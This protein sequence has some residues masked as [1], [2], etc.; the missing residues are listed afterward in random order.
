MASKVE[1]DVI[2]AT[3]F[4]QKL[5][6]IKTLFVPLDIRIF[7][8]KSISNEN[9]A[10]KLSKNGVFWYF[11]HILHLFLGFLLLTFSMYLFAALLSTLN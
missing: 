1:A 2:I 7:A 9:T 3:T 5:S 11:D 8:L 10:H 6:Q 4:A